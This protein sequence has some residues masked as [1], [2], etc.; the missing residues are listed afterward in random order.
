M[1]LYIQFISSIYIYIFNLLKGINI[2]F[3]CIIIYIKLVSI[4]ITHLKSV[5]IY[6]VNL[7]LVYISIRNL[8]LV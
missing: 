4:K 6:N 3:N 1:S 7:K 5:S 2:N 8:K